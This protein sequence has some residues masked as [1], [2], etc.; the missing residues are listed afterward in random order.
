MLIQ[1]NPPIP[2]ITPHGPSLAH[3]IIDNGI[4]NHLQWVCFNDKTGEC[5]TWENPKIRAQKNTTM[6]RDHI[7]P[8]YLPESVA[9]ISRKRKKKYKNRKYKL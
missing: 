6:G 5:W 7:S 8:F 9:L 4:E 3:F 2:L 1:L